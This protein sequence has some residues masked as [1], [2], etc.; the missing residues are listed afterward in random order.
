MSF[1]KKIILEYF[2]LIEYLK[3]N[4]KYTFGRSG[5][6]YITILPKQPTDS[7]DVFY[8]ICF[9]TIKN[10]NKL[11]EKKITLK[12]LILHEIENNIKKCIKLSV[13]STPFVNLNIKILKSTKVFSNNKNCEIKRIYPIK[14]IYNVN[15]I[16]KSIM[17]GKLIIEKDYFFIVQNK[18][19]KENDN[20]DNDEISD[21]EILID[22]KNAHKYQ[23]FINKKNAM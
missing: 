7:A 18:D 6:C 1:D 9:S 23:M 20:D 2:H 12:K 16:K 5:P 13:I 10:L 17:Y 4:T 11:F 21:N 8:S 22:K 14:L 19:F 3:L 15:K